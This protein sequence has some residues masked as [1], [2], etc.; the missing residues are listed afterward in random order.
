MIDS[1]Y[2]WTNILFLA[3]G[4]LMIRG[5]FIAM[6]SRIRI[7]DRLREIFSFIPA[8]VLPAFVAPAVFFNEG[9]QAWLLGKER[10][11]VLIV[12]TAVCFYSKSTLLTILFGLGFLYLLNK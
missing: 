7:S 8:A 11:F 10:F 5:T 9:H 12:S 1:N 2:F 4:T 3:A 6:S